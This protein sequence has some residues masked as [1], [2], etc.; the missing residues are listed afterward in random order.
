MNRGTAIRVGGAVL[1]AGSICWAVTLLVT[2]PPEDGVSPRLE[3][4]GGFAYQLGL[5]GLL[6]AV[7]L[8][9]GLGR[10][11][12]AR[13]VLVTETALLALASVWSVVYAI[14]HR[15]QEH[16]VMVVLD[17][18]WPLSMLGL[19]VLGIYLVLARVWPTLPRQLALVASLWLPLDLAATLIG[20]DTA[21]LA[22]RVTWLMV[23]WGALG[24]L[25]AVFGERL[26]R[27]S[28]GL[29][30]GDP[31]ARVRQPGSAV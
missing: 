28:G 5:A 25:I 26:G 11:P 8:T 20:G 7:W 6:L 23:V 19:V 14:D 30:E 21:G 4:L 18:T 9:G 15:T 10:V 24:V 31:A 2:E 22:F 3:I 29:V 12:G 17:A 13:V 16:L 1:T 27:T